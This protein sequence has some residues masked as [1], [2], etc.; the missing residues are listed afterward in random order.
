MS[1]TYNIHWGC[2]W[3]P[4]GVFL[5]YSQYYRL[6]LVHNG[7]H[8]CPYSPSVQEFPLVSEKMSKW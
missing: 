8:H 5:K 4:F 6:I 2:V 3:I 7:E 1:T